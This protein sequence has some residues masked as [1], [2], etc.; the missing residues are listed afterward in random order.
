LSTCGDAH[1]TNSIGFESFPTWAGIIAECGPKNMDWQGSFGPMPGHFGS[2]IC[3][4]NLSIQLCGVER[5]ASKEQGP[6]PTG[7]RWPLSYRERKRGL[8]GGGCLRYRV[9]SFFTR[10]SFRML[11]HGALLYDGGRSENCLSRSVKTSAPAVYQLHND[12]CSAQVDVPK[13]A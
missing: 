12:I 2:F 9:W 4:I 11:C 1:C 7:P 13:I 5:S 10:V 3:A 6:V 8:E